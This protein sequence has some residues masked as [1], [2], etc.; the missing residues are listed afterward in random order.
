M[1]RTRE[2]TKHMRERIQSSCHFPEDLFEQRPKKGEIGIDDSS[3]INRMLL[4]HI[5][6]ASANHLEDLRTK[7]DAA[8][9][10]FDVG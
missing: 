7:V 3:S 2:T 1:C 10:I 5:Q 4:T 8:F 9:Y 6:S